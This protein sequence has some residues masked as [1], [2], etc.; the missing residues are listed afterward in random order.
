MSIDRIAVPVSV[1]VIVRNGERH[2]QAALDSIANQTTAP[3]EVVVIDG[4]STDRSAA[5]AAAAGARVIAQHGTG[6]ADA[7][8]QGIE[9]AAARLIAFL[10]HDDLWEPT[11][12]E[13]QARA[14][15]EN[16]ALD[17]T[18]SQLRF[19][20]LDGVACPPQI[21]PASLGVQ[22]TAGTPGALVA[23]RD[24]FD[25]IGRFDRSLQLACDAEWFAR[26]RSAGLT[27][28]TIRGPGLIKRLHRSNASNDAALNRAEMIEVVRRSIRWK[29]MGLTT[30]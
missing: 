14:M 8:N 28:A 9:S 18:L 19:E 10:D 25:R 4:A 22:I 1:I 16:P 27:T 2:L 24:V 12:L 3:E 26:A 6:I 20:V 15:I 17:Y 7:R 23:R 21:D 5:I 29:R 30:P 13:R 11:K